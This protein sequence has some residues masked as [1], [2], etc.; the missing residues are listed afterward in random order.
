[1]QSDN[2]PISP[3]IRTIRQQQS[4]QYQQGE[5]TASTTTQISA[6]QGRISD[7]GVSQSSGELEQSYG[8]DPLQ[9]SNHRATAPATATTTTAIDLPSLTVKLTLRYY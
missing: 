5:A 7:E 3:P 4:E 1:M 2:F 8:Q 6:Y 9:R